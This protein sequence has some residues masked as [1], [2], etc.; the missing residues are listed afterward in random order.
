[1]LQEENATHKMYEVSETG[2]SHTA[3]QTGGAAST[4]GAQIWET[5]KKES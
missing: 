5:D 3:L 2:P 1:M 4:A